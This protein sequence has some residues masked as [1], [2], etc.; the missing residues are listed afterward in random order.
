MMGFARMTM[1]FGLVAGIT[2]SGARAET[3][4]AVQKAALEKR[5]TCVKQRMTRR[6]TR[7]DTNKDGVV[8]RAE[9]R[10]ARRARRQKTLATYDKNQ[11]GKLSKEE[12]TQ[13]R[14]DR[15]LSRFERIDTDRNGEITRAE[16][17]AACGPLAMFF[18]RVDKTNDGTVS[19]SEFEVAA[20]RF[21]KHRRHMKRR[22]GHGDAMPGFFGP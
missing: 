12:R 1:V 21:V 13:A 18:D 8:D 7:V 16:A 20:K 2:A 10:A 3:L 17:N 22:L 6:L 4:S 15:M 14:H 11:D 9:R 19:W 5:L